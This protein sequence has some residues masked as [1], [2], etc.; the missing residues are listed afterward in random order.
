MKPACMMWKP[1]DE[2]ATDGPGEC[3]RFDKRWGTKGVADL[4]GA[5]VN[6]MGVGQ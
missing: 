4:E 3:S 6:G 2:A 5:S 1:A